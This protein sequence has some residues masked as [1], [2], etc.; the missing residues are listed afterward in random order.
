MRLP[1][2]TN[3]NAPTQSAMKDV[4]VAHNAEEGV[5]RVQ[6]MRER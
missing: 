3:T 1:L 4:R 5:A 6:V 2:F